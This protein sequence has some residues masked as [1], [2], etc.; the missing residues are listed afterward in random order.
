MGASH[1]SHKKKGQKEKEACFT[2]KK[3][4]EDHLKPAT[5]QLKSFI[6]DI[7]HMSKSNSDLGHIAQIQGNKRQGK[8]H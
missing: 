3:K 8:N 7:F 2:E 5:L 4:I 1:L 6:F